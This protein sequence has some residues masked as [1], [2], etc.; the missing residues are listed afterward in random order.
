MKKIIALALAFCMLFAFAACTKTEKES[1]EMVTFITEGKMVIGTTASAEPFTYLGEDGAATGL[2]IDV[3]KA[4][5][6]EMNATPEVVVME[7]MDKLIEALNNNEIDVIA[8]VMV[9]NDEN[10]Q[11]A[12]LTRAYYT[13]GEGD[14][15]V[16]YVFGV[17]RSKDLLH[18]SI[19]ASMDTVIA[20]PSI[21]TGETDEQ[22]NPVKITQFDEIKAKYFPAEEEPA[23]E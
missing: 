7:S 11:L 9:Q 14:D 1:D 18:E 6:A 21:E 2:A 8:D 4:A 20:V 22:G 10:K 3:A 23:A 19:S 16:S 12:R 5:A 17:K 15:A 13:E